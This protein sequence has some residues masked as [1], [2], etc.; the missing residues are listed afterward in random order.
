L[1]G[2]D[3]GHQVERNKRHRSHRSDQKLETETWKAQK[4]ISQSMNSAFDPDHFNVPQHEDNG[5]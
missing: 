4:N 2:I 5:N 1:Q 3:L